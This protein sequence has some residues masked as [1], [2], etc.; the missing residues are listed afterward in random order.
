MTDSTER[1]L[2]E[3]HRVLIIM[4][5]G[6]ERPG[7]A[8]LI[9]RIDAYLSRPKPEA[10]E[11]PE[12]DAEFKIYPQG[13]STAQLKLCRSLERRLRALSGER[14]GLVIGRAQGKYRLVYNK[15]TRKIDKVSNFDGLAVESFDPPKDCSL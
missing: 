9:D 12:T 7:I 11:T 15:Q 5:K 8:E 6:D 13:W 2:R 3:C 4:S 14:E 1:L 10:G